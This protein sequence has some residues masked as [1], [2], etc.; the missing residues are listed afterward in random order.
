[1]EINNHRLLGKGITYI[2][3]PN[4]GGAYASGYPDTLIMHYTAC[5]N[6]ESAIRILTD[7]DSEHRVSAH[8]VIG[9]DG[10]VTQLLPFDI[11]GWHAG[12]SSWDGREAFNQYSLGI[13]IDNAGQLEERYGRYLSWFGQEY[14][15]EEVVHTIHRNQQEATYWQIYTPEQLEVVEELARLLVSTYGLRYILGH[16]EIA[17]DRKVDPGPAYP[18]E[19][20]RHKLLSGN[21]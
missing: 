4:Q 19:E 15:A 6:A 9:R 16:E 14:P 1:M 2:E 8:L 17:P 21:G 13:E 7:G 10:A 5:P 20:L 11:I 18:L 3:S 12:V